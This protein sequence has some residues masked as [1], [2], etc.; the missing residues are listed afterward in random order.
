MADTSSGNTPNT[1]LR[2]PPHSLIGPWP[3]TVPPAAAQLA[4]W[5]VRAKPQQAYIWD[6]CPSFCSPGQTRDWKQR[7]G[8][9]GLNILNPLRGVTVPSGQQ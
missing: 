4:A 8:S 1:L 2:P 9:F 5:T 6:T 7:K 3:G